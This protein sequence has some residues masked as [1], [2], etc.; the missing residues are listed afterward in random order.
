MS[1]PASA[2]LYPQ[3]QKIH[4]FW[5][6]EREG[7]EGVG[8]GSRGGGVRAGGGGLEKG[9]GILAERVPN[10]PLVGGGS[11]VPVLVE[12]VM[13]QLSELHDCLEGRSGVPY[14]VLVRRGAA[15]C[16]KGS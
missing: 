8:A 2:W 5:G 9:N 1:Y 13:R 16:L 14:R 10:R 15:Q 6:A 11:L 3:S 7:R 4:A 12:R